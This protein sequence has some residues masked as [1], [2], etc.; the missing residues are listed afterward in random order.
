M[1]HPDYPFTEFLSDYAACNLEATDDMRTDNQ[2]FMDWFWIFITR[3]YPDQATA[4]YRGFR[5]IGVFVNIRELRDFYATEGL[6][7]KTT[8][9]R[10]IADNELVEALYEFTCGPGDIPGMPV[11]SLVTKRAKE[12]RAA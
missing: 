6:G 10:F 9:G 2:S 5:L 1:E 8:S 12:I 3:I 4:A 7:R 11:K